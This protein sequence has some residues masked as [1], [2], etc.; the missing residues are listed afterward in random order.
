MT[1]D[2]HYY[3]VYDLQISSTLA[4]P[5]LPVLDPEEVSPDVHIREGRVDPVTENEDSAGERRIHATRNDW[6]LTYEGIGSVRVTG[7]NNIVFDLVKP[8]LAETKAL[9]RLVAN[10]AFA[11]LLL[12]QGLLVLH[13]SSVSVDGRAVVFLGHRTAGKSTTAAAF[14][15]HGY[16]V[17][18]D[19]VIGIR[20]DKETPHVVPGVPEIR[21][22]PD[23]VA[24]L[25]IN[26]AI[27]PTGDGGP[28]RL[29]CR[30]SG[31]RSPTP[32]FRCYQLEDAESVEIVKQSGT[33]SFLTIVAGTYAQG[34]LSDTD[35]TDEHF[36]QCRAT[37]D[38][39]KVRTLRRPRSIGTLPTVVEAVVSDVSGSC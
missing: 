10:H 27:Q 15:K 13:A 37:L 35:R 5:E 23:A 16:Q 28:E 18:G 20:F 26:D 29:Y 22:A 1:V 12:Q 39:A 3:S 9:R 14:H 2:T 33:Q 24:G 4:F 19:D 31:D 36:D 7:G 38:T 21:L 25:D 17:L 30:L 34:L 8:A 32:L 11:V 6:R